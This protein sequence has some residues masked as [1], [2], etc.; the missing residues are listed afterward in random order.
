MVW[1]EVSHGLPELCCIG[2]HQCQC[3]SECKRV[4][5][6]RSDVNSVFE[7]PSVKAPGLVAV[8]TEVQTVASGVRDE[9]CF[10]GYFV[11]VYFQVRAGVVLPLQEVVFV[12]HFPEL[13]VVKE[14]RHVHGLLVTGSL[15]VQT[16]FQG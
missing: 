7:D 10:V 11:Q 15:V 8:E 9:S 1:T 16:V 3:W 12:N 4:W 14:L 6:A 13:T 2:W 5:T